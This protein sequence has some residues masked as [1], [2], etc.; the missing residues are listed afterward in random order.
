MITYRRL[1]CVTVTL[2]VVVAAAIPGKV[3]YCHWAAVSAFEGRAD[4]GTVILGEEEP[5][6]GKWV[7]RRWYS[8]LFGTVSYVQMNDE[9][10]TAQD[11]SHLRNLRGLKELELPDVT[12][13]AWRLLPNQLTKLDVGARLNN[14]ALQEIAKLDQLEHLSAWIPLGDDRRVASALAGHQR[15]RTLVLSG[16]V[17]PSTLKSLLTQH[18]RLENLGLAWSEA[19]ELERISRQPNLKWLWV[20]M[21]RPDYQRLKALERL[22]TLKVLCIN[23]PEDLDDVDSEILA[24]FAASRPDL[25]VSFYPPTGPMCGAV[26]PAP[27]PPD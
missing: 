17:S 4:D 22:T 25:E 19:I 6:F 7:N 2:V 8:K 18:P 1:V 24:K 10:C 21:Q 23:R 3:L 5:A 27:L 12:D 20:N 16:P 14:V 26:L 9:N 13:G 15:L 11:I